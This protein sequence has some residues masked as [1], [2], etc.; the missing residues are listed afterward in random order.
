MIT[1][2][3]YAL[4]TTKT[5]TIMMNHCMGNVLAPCWKN[6]TRFS[7]F[8]SAVKTGDKLNLNWSSSESNFMAHCKVK[9]RM[10]FGKSVYCPNATCI[11]MYNSIY[12][13]ALNTLRIQVRT[14]FCQAMC[15]TF[16]NK[17]QLQI[18][19]INVFSKWTRTSNV[20]TTCCPEFFSVAIL[21]GLRFVNQ[22]WN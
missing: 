18:V 17:P 22:V 20:W 8:I 15:D 9:L 19:V 4:T 13:A 21:L 10:S 5:I 12:R 16:V 3:M 14:C 1:R 7:W 11:Y 6:C 2:Q